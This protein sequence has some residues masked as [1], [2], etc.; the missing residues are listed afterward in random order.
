MVFRLKELTEAA[1]HGA[2]RGV[3]WN[4]DRAE[5]V[6]D[7]VVHT[8][9]VSSGVIA[10]AILIVLACL[11]RSGTEV[12]AVIVYGGGL[13][14]MLGISATYN[15]LPVSPVK[16]WLRRFDHSAIYLL[17]A[18]T[19]TP[20]IARIH[21]NVYALALLIG[22]W[23][24][25][26]TGTFLKIFCPGRFDRVSIGLYLAMGWSGVML[27]DTL[28]TALP[29]TTLALIAVGGTL[30][31]LGVIFHVWERLRFQNAIW[32]SFVLLGAGCHYVAVLGLVM[33]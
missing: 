22:I 15:L 6:A 25:A 8:V 13:L 12:A 32:H 7:G 11:Y 21:G 1:L 31:S 24:V 18:A 3:R 23:L 14:A 26:V 2:P 28:V 10:T 9:G 17:V 29:A 30:Y 19:Y 4:Y 27:Y 16:W 33:A 5:I 20:F